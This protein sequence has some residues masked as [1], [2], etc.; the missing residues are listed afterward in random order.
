MSGFSKHADRW[1][2]KKGAQFT[3]HNGGPTGHAMRLEL[4]S[5]AV[6]LAVTRSMTLEHA[7][8]RLV[9]LLKERIGEKR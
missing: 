1:I 3:T 5:E 9:A 2:K 8:P 6:Q 4:G 7:L